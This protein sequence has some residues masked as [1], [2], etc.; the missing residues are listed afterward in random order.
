MMAGILGA[1]AAAIRVGHHKMSIR[2][3]LS[4]GYREVY[5]TL[6]PWRVEFWP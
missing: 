4:E 3:S 6:Y 2:D 1:P 5:N